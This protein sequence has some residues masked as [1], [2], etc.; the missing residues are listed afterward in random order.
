[1][2]RILLDL[3]NG[4]FQEDWLFLEREDAQR[5]PVARLGWEASH[6]NGQEARGSTAS[7]LR[8]KCVPWLTVTAN[9]YAFFRFTLITTRLIDNGECGVT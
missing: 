3:K 8:K 6:A 1:M 5:M 4:F 2:A 7:A 9:S